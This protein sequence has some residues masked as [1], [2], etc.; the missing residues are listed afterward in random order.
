MLQRR[1]NSQQGFTILC[2]SIPR[3]SRWLLGQTGLSSPTLPC[4]APTSTTLNAPSVPRG[5]SVGPRH[6]N[7]VSVLRTR[8]RN[9][10]AQ[11]SVCLAPREPLHRLGRR[12]VCLD[13]RVRRGTRRLCTPS[14]M[15]SVERRRYSSLSPR[16]VRVVSLCRQTRARCVLHATRASFET[17][18]RVRIVP[19]APSRRSSRRRRAHSQDV[20]SAPHAPSL[21]RYG[22]TT[23]RSPPMRLRAISRRDAEGA[24]AAPMAG[25]SWATGWT[26][27]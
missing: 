3:T 15:A 7:V 12:C 21:R 19:T 20:H 1:L 17:V 9:R 13:L 27:V 24:S 16:S 2:G 25:A 23:R 10:S 18:R 6:K 8:L 22:T 5:T 14:V 11:E 26:R 4:L